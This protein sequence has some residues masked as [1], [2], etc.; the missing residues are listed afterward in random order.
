LCG[1][2]AQWCHWERLAER[3]EALFEEI[4]EHRDIQIRFNLAPT[5][6]AWIVRERDGVRYSQNGNCTPL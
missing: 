3:Y 1:R 2:I 5:Q 6:E 4:S